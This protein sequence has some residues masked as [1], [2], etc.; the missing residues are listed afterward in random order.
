MFPLQLTGASLALPGV[1]DDLGADLTAAQWIV[2]AYAV[3]FAAALAVAGTLADIFGR[4]RVFATGVALFFVGGLLSALAGN[5]SLLVAARGLSGLG[6][7]AAAAS[8]AAILAATFEGGAKRRAFGLLGTVLGGGLAFGPM[9]S[10]ALVDVLGWRA[11]FGVPAVVAG[12]VLAL[13]PVLPRAPGDRGRRRGNGPLF[14]LAVA[15][16][17]RFVAFAVAAASFM[18][19]LVP[20]VVYVPSYLITVVEATPGAAGLWMLMLTVPTVLL[21]PVGSAVA[22]RV[23]IA[24][25][26][27]GSITLSGAGSLALVTI[28]PDSTPVELLL[29][30]AAVGAGVGLTMGVLDG[31]AIDSV[32]P[33]QA[34]AANGLFNTARLATEAIALAAAGAVL[35]A[36]SGGALHG[37]A[38]TDAI[39]V[40]CVAL[41]VFALVCSAL[42]V[43]LLRRPQSS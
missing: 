29:P 35:A 33:S 11:V 25:F 32:P 30:F 5:V 42:V 37:E 26:V 7:A 21:P 14:G 43:A 10:G 3:V 41:A 27:A 20:L 31:L 9:V 6:A 8:G 1:T 13:A 2:N 28:G 38:F 40:L 18:G 23:P 19:I 17:R 22:Q 36:V 34:G 12:L 15:V 4:R 16:N 39:R 24:V